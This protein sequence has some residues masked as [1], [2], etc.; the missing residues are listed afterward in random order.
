MKILLALAAFALVAVLVVSATMGADT[1]VPGGDSAKKKPVGGL[2]PSGGKARLLPA[3][4]SPPSIKGTGFKPGENVT[5]KF[6]D[7][8]KA[9]R[10][11]KANGSGSFTILMPERNNQCGNLSAVAVGDKGSRA[12][13]QFAQVLCAVPSQSQ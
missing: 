9:T 2:A 3:S 10:R 1:L 5:V 7:G 4:L 8:P 11:A 6:V 13:F 12:S